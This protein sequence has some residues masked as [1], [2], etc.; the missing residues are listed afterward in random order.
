MVNMNPASS[1]TPFDA[2]AKDAARNSNAPAQESAPVS[3]DAF[4]RLLVAQL[5]HQDPLNPADGT[6]FL[7]QLAG[8]SQLE[9]TIAMKDELKEI[10]MA[11]A[12][13][14]APPE[15]GSASGTPNTDQEKSI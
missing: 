1:Q 5:Q 4:M 14:G 12:S 3:K 8:F 10:R 2:G 13:W 15:S 7:T 6:E 11:L 9:Q